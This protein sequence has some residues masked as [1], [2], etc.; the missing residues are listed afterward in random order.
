M[1]LL[2]AV[3]GEAEC[4]VT[5]DADLLSL[6]STGDKLNPGPRISTLQAFM[7]MLDRPE[8]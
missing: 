8:P 3:V 7:E 2:L 4:L 1:F 6:A 5:G